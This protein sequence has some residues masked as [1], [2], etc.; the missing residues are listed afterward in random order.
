MTLSR[1]VMK[2]GRSLTRKIA[3]WQRITLFECPV[4][5]SDIMTWNDL[6]GREAAGTGTPP[7]IR[8]GYNLNRASLAKLSRFRR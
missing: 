5:R 6:H 4:W 7:S 2:F 1:L 3:V 8:F